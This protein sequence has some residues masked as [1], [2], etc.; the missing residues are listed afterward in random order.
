M[1]RGNRSE[2]LILRALAFLVEQELNR[3]NGTSPY[4]KTLA[5]LIDLKNEATSAQKVIQDE[6]E[7]ATVAAEAL[8]LVQ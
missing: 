2:L 8:R 5:L 6:Q 1:I 4:D 3:P 7:A